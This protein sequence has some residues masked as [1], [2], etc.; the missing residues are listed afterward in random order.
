VTSRA[1]G[2]GETRR[3]FRSTK[4]AALSFDLSCLFNSRVT[5]LLPVLDATLQRSI[6]RSGVRAAVSAIKRTDLASKSLPLRLKPGFYLVRRRPQ[7]FDGGHIRHKGSIE[8]ATVIEVRIEMLA[9]LANVP[10][11][12]R[13]RCD[14]HLSELH[15][16]DPP[17]RV[18][19]RHFCLPATFF[20]ECADA[21]IIALGIV[22]SIEQTQ[23]TF[24]ERSLLQPR[25]AGIAKPQFSCICC[26][27]LRLW[28]CSC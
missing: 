17:S 24:P 7:W 13:K 10:S 20:V 25:V 21:R 27:S 6:H 19:T 28:R 3:A 8:S 22:S 5:C 15:R 1:G 4:A 23:I 14:A 9:I 12:T 26:S 18:L 2:L 16:C 11:V